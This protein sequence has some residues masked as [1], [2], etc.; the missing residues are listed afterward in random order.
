MYLTAGFHLD[1]NSL[2]KFTVLPKCLDGFRGPISEGNG[3][4][5]KVVK[6]EGR[7]GRGGKGKRVKRREGAKFCLFQILK[8]SRPTSPCLCQVGR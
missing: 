7:K 6:G 8:A 4:E 2:G 1:R 5:R 3:K